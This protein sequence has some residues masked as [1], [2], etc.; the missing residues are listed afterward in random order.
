MADVPYQPWFRTVHWGSWI[1]VFTT[2]LIGFFTNGG[3]LPTDS[4]GWVVFIA[5]VL[6]WGATAYNTVTGANKLALPK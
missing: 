1:A 4:N 5:W 3:H 2:S 6:S